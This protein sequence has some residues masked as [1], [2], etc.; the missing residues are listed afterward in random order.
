MYKK[1]YKIIMNNFTYSHGQEFKF[2]DKSFTYVYIHTLNNLCYW[3]VN[4]INGSSY[5]NTHEKGWSDR[6]IFINYMIPIPKIDIKLK[7]DIINRTKDIK[8]LNY[9]TENNIIKLNND[10]KN[11]IVAFMGYAN[12]YLKLGK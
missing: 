5:I 10:I 4:T 3:S 6:L 7:F 12:Y 9:I 1:K 8:Y 11:N 2:T